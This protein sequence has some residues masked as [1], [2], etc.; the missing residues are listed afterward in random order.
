[1]NEDHDWSPWVLGTRPVHTV[2]QRI[3][4]IDELK[5]LDEE[6]VETLLKL[7]S[8]SGGTVVNPNTVNPS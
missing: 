8:R 5:I 2:D 4:H 7:F 3:D 1:M 6:E